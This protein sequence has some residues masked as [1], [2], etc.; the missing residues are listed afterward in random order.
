LSLEEDCISE[1]HPIEEERR[2]LV[3]M[4]SPVLTLDEE[5]GK[6]DAGYKE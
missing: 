2:N 5:V 3:E 6:M 4:G 1:L